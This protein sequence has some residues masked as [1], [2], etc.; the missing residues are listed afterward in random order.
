MLDRKC[1]TCGVN[2]LL[3]RPNKKSIN[4]KKCAHAI[5]YS[6]Y[7][8]NPENKE[9]VRKTREEYKKNN[10][11]KIKLKNKEYRDKNKDKDSARQKE[12]YVL[13]A[14][15]I[16]IRQ[17]K[18]ISNPEVRAKRNQAEK[19][20]SKTNIQF[21]LGKCMSHA[22]RESLKIND[23]TKSKAKWQSIVGYTI[24]QL[25]DHLEK[26]F[27]EN[28]SWE[29]YGSYWHIDHIE[30]QSWFKYDSIDHPAFKSCWALDNLRPL[31]AKENIRKGN[32]YK[33]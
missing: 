31:E 22:I 28:M 8:S 2:F 4:C 23:L 12:Y 33:R 13:N 17:K 20:K 5:R 32:R 29:N 10:I 1:K 18:Y 3:K 7:I 16:L 9:Y 21:R 11:E 15:K 27:D 30:P 24:I 25:K 19:E 6:R 14:E 26:L